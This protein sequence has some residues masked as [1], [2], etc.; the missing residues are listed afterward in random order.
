MAEFGF[1][2]P[3]PNAEWQAAPHLVPKAN[4]KALFRTTID[5][6]PIN[7]ATFPR[8]WPMYHLDSELQDFAGSKLF[9]VLD[10]VS[11]YWQL[12]I[13][14]LCYTLCGIVTPNGVYSST[15][16]LQGL[17]NVVSYFQSTIESL[18]AELREWMKAWIDDFNL[19]TESEHMLLDKIERFLEIGHMHGLFISAKKTQFFAHEVR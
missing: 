17:T 16:V 6:R 2:V 8:S 9:A 14:P 7:S 15:R 18:F 11:G 4:S 5:L 1:L 10:F 12:P 3:N 19:H 13:H